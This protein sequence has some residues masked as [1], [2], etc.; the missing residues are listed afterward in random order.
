MEL[1]TCQSRVRS[2]FATFFPKL[3]TKDRDTWGMTLVGTDGYWTNYRFVTGQFTALQ[4]RIRLI[5]DEFSPQR[6]RM[7]ELDT[8]RLFESVPQVRPTSFAYYDYAGRIDTI[9]RETVVLQYASG[10]RVALPRDF[11]VGF[12]G[13]IVRSDQPW[14]METYARE[15]LTRMRLENLYF[16]QAFPNMPVDQPWRLRAA[17]ERQLRDLLGL[18]WTQ[19]RTEP[20]PER[21]AEVVRIEE[22]INL[23][24]LD[25]ARW[26][27]Y[28]G[29]REHRKGLGYPDLSGAIRLWEVDRVRQLFYDETEPWMMDLPV[30]AESEITALRSAYLAAGSGRFSIQ[31]RMNPLLSTAE[32]PTLDNAH[33][34]ITYGPHRA[35]GLS[36]PN[37]PQM[38]TPQDPAIVGVGTRRVGNQTV[39]NDPWLGN[40]PESQ[41]WNVV[42]AESESVPEPKMRVRSRLVNIATSMAERIES[43]LSS[44]KPVLIY[45]P[46]NGSSRRPILVLPKTFFNVQVAPLFGGG[47]NLRSIQ[48]DNTVSGW[49]TDGVGPGLHQRIFGD[50][51]AGFITTPS[52][53]RPI[54]DGFIQEILPYS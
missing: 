1:F 45:E 17:L 27:H 3:L 44:D 49:A 18:V 46:L 42:Q 28:L 31:L 40:I 12:R 37:H 8:V 20:T 50:A 4:A 19:Y 35:M 11:A 47:R 15:E 36:M 41:A 14:S 43:S 22:E 53:G 23:Y 2:S 10:Q 9:S 33:H 39:R 6:K 13:I 54:R 38:I 51:P 29:L 5:A 21:F 48:P 16:G 24:F 30:Q 32:H 25:S 7:P 34:M 26:L 52:A